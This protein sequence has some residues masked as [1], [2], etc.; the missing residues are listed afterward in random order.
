[1]V[2]L[3]DRWHLG[4]CTKS[5]TASLAAMLIEDGLLRWDT[6]V[7]EILPG[8]RHEPRMATSHDRGVTPASWRRPARSAV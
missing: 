3:D 6:T 2:T 8:N 1:M 7:G 5:M 4:S